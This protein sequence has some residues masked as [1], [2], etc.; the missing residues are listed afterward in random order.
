MLTGNS[1]AN[2]ETPPPRAFYGGNPLGLLP[3]IHPALAPRAPP[4]ADPGPGEPAAAKGRPLSRWTHL[5]E[6]ERHGE[7]TDPYYAV[8]Y[9]GDQPPVGGGGR[10]H[11]AVS[12]ARGPRSQALD[13]RRMRDPRGTGGCLEAAA[14]REG[15]RDSQPPDLARLSGCLMASPPSPTSS[16]GRLRVP[17]PTRGRVARHQPG[18]PQPDFTAAS[19][20]TL[21]PSAASSARK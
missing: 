10:R 21:P 2:A 16:R 19:A 9:V 1:P 12:R 18:T 14:S 15:G 6:A 13:D 5:F 7:H 8:H 20:R 3:H 11:S 4:T 17:A